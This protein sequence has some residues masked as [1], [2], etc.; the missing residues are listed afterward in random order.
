[1]GRYKT[2]GKIRVSLANG[3]IEVEG[4]DQ[5][6]SKYEDDIRELLDRLKEQPV[7]AKAASAGNG[8]TMATRS[9]GVI[10]G[11][12]EFGEVLH[13]LPKGATGSDQILVAGYFA[14]RGNTEQTF[15]TNE[16]NRLLVEQG[17]KLSNPSQSLRN[18]L[19]VKRVFKV[20]SRYRVSNIG[21]Q[22]VLSL[23]GQRL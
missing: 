7:P 23:V 14:A 1:M 3:E 19:S 16:A 13:A 12:S 9:P 10:G 5:F 11:A 4:P 20:G 6:V 17:I 22:H 18:N 15:S 2:M 21:E 8:Q